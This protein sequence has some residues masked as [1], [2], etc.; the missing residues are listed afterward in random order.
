MKHIT[1]ITATIRI[2]ALINSDRKTKIEVSELLGIARTTLD[3]RLKNND[4]S[5]GELEIIKSL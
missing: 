3:R 1:S 4:W 5:K 2:N